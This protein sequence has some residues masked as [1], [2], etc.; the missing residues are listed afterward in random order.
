MIRQRYFCY[1]RVCYSFGLSYLRNSWSWM[2]N[3]ETTSTYLVLTYFGWVID[4][5]R[6]CEATFYLA[7]SH[8]A[9]GSEWYALDLQL[10]LLGF[11]I[12]EFYRSWNVIAFD[13]SNFICHPS[14]SLFIIIMS[15]TMTIIALDSFLAFI[16]QKYCLIYLKNKLYVIIDIFI[17]I[18]IC[19]YDW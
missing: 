5:L 7:R 18:V 2:V 1:I 19:H 15:K 9:P 16:S 10:R 13:S 14:L 17:S 11:R 6:R 12:L 4:L 3:F 8:D